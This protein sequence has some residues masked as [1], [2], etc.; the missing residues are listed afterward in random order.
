MSIFKKQELPKEIELAQKIS[1]A[2]GKYRHL[3]CGGVYEDIFLSSSN[4]LLTLRLFKKENC[5]GEPYCESFMIKNYD[6]QKVDTNLLIFD[7]HK[8]INITEGLEDIL[9][10]EVLIDLFDI[11]LT[12]LIN[13]ITKRKESIAKSITK[14]IN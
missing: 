6:S 13:R 3:H 10:K 9:T 12:R 2:L 8:K 1:F 4:C 11:I 7:G 5:A 14:F